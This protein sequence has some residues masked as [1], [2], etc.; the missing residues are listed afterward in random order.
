M[1]SIHCP[2]PKAHKHRAQHDTLLT[3]NY[4][5]NDSSSLSVVT[6]IKQKKQQ[7]H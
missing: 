1:K 5:L 2:T 3:R 6:C 7:N 4:L